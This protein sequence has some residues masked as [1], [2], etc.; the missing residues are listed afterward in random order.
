[1]K[2]FSVVGDSSATGFVI[3][4]TASDF[5]F[6]VLASRLRLRVGYTRSRKRLGTLIRN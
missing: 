4:T 6:R 2:G 3:L 5:D 1:V